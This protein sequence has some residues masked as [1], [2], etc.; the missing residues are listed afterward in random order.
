MNFWE[1]VWASKDNEKDQAEEAP[2]Q[3]PSVEYTN[4]Q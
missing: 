2:R 4:N 3:R 1:N